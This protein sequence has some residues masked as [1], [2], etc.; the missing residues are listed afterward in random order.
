MT[1]MKKVG[2]FALFLWPQLLLA[3]VLDVTLHYVGPTQGQTWSGIQQGLSEANLQGEFLGQHYTIKPISVDEL[4]KLGA[5]TAIL[6]ATDADHILE[7]AQQPQF[8]NVPVFNLSSDADS[9]REACLPNLLHLP[10][11]Q[12]MKAD[13]LAQ[14][15]AKNPG[16]AVKAQAWHEDFVKFAAAQLNIRFTRNHTSKM[17]DD[18]WAGWAAVKMLSD[19]VARTQNPDAEAMLDYLKNAL[20]FDGQKG[21]G[22]TFRQTGQL[23][24]I[25]LLVNQDN[26]IV[27]EAP[28]RGVKG[29]LDS[30]GI[31]SCK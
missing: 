3:E 29:G 15:Q 11:S 30:L 25:V 27:A 10:I 1:S 31:N 8:A 28:L 5:V 14:W 2:L 17:D 6:L 22:A 9:L 23:R 26:A 21:D 16:V 7:V 13:A 24:Q 12:R 20:A 18:A 4:E 19:T